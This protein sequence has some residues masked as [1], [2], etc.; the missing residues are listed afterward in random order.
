RPY[1]ELFVQGL[2][3]LGWVEGRNV[4]VEY[5]YTEGSLERVAEAASEFVRMKVDVIVTGGDREILTVKKATATI[6]IVFA[7]TGA[8]VGN[9]MIA[10][11]VRPGGNITGLSMALSE[12]AG[13]R[14]ELLREVVPSLSHLAVIGNF[15]NPM[16]GPEK[17]A[18]L[19]A[20]RMLSLETIAI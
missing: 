13:K 3:Q 1:A 11:L 6:P 5:R 20:A 19:A 4:H 12:T 10:S 17:N 8:P 2:R 15:E 18:V 14:L 16:V 7:S 9:G